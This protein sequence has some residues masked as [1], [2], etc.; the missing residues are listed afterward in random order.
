[1]KNCEEMVNSLLERRERYELEKKRK[2]TA[3]LRLTI[4]LG[5]VCLLVCACFLTGQDKSIKGNRQGED[6]TYEIPV[7]NFEASLPDSDSDSFGVDELEHIE[8]IIDENRIYT[9]LD[10]SEYEKCGI[11]AVLSESDFGETLGI[12]EEIAS[13]SETVPAPCSQ[14]S[15]LAGCEVYYYASAE[16]EAAII[17]KGNGCCSVFAFRGFKCEGYS[18]KETLTILGINSGDDISSISFDVRNIVGETVRKG[19]IDDV[20]EK[21]TIYS[22][23]AQLKPYTT[24]NSIQGIPNWLLEATESYDYSTAL[25]VKISIESNCRFSFVTEYQPYLGTGYIDLNEF[26]SSEQNEILMSLLLN[27]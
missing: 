20:N 6:S 11:G 2:K 1:M 23:F 26:L 19:V 7:L 22:I 3:A 15:K 10:E 17:V 9:Q 24:D 4:C 16:C 21:N 12:I 27:G 8:V 13:W 18:I 5:G 25:F 14:E